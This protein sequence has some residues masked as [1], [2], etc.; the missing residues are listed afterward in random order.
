MDVKMIPYEQMTK[1]QKDKVD[2]FARKHLV[3]ILERLIT[4]LDA[5]LPAPGNGYVV[6]RSV[7]SCGE[8]A[9]NDVEFIQKHYKIDPSFWSRIQKLRDEGE[10]YLQSLKA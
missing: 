9:V 7:E 5:S 10:A 8:I 2:G 6:E 3:D 4:R 1:K